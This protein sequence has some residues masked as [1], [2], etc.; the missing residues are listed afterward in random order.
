MVAIYYSLAYSHVVQSIIIWGGA[1]NTKI[2][3]MRV[4]LN[5]ILR[6][7]LCVKT[8]NFHVPLLSSNVCH[9]SNVCHA[10]V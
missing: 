7:I 10:L 2:N 5:K 3:K 6:V 1:L 9:V 8:D 4:A